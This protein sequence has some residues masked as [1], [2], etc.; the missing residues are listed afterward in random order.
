MNEGLKSYIIE[1]LEKHWSPE[2]ISGRSGRVSFKSIYNWIYNGLVKI[3]LTVLRRKGKS[4]K[5]K[6]TRGNFNI[7]TS[8]CNR[9]KSVKKRENLVIGN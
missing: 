5:P 2:Q 1:K 6:E 8:I 3:P 4:R 9:P 7:G